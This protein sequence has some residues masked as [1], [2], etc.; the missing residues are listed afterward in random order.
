MNVIKKLI[1]TII[2]II[3]LLN[4]IPSNVY[5]QQNPTNQTKLKV[6]VF[7]NNFDDLFLNEVKK[8]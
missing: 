6:A 5:A 7:I 8:T 3:L 4:I 1:S 2:V